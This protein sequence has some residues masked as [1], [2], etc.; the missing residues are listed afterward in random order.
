MATGIGPVTT[1]EATR[2][3]QDRARATHA[4]AIMGLMNLAIR[5]DA[6]IETGQ[7][8]PGNV[9]TI[10]PEALTMYMALLRAQRVDPLVAQNLFQG[11]LEDVESA[12]KANDIGEDIYK[13]K[14]TALLVPYL[15]RDYDA[16]L[17][18]EAH[19][20]DVNGSITPRKLHTAEFI[21][22]ICGDGDVALVGA[23]I[24]T[25]KRIIFLVITIFLV[26]IMYRIWSVSD[27]AAQCNLHDEGHTQGDRAINEPGRG[28][29]DAAGR[30]FIRLTLGEGAAVGVVEEAVSE[31]SHTIVDEVAYRNCN[32][33]QVGAIREIRRWKLVAQGA[34]IFMLT[35]GL[36]ALVLGEKA[37]EAG[38]E[39]GKTALR[40]S[41]TALDLVASVFT[42]HKGAGG[43]PGGRKRLPA[44][45]RRKS[46]AAPRRKTPAPPRR[47]PRLRDGG[48]IGT[49]VCASCGQTA[50]TVCAQ[51]ETTHYCSVDCQR[52]DWNSTHAK[53]CTHSLK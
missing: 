50:T 52:Q 8:V 46:P 3:F 36:S 22:S 23:G 21:A 19:N 5:A 38:T 51:C 49:P 4:N 41:K 11:V 40:T 15:T 28:L 14:F 2:I 13:G 1:E 26:V 17:A 25:K 27:L 34:V 53:V 31:T 20:F 44:P 33:E 43:E 32:P 18:D 10:I 12:S 42:S 47:S 39:A 9:H 16:Y 6:M 45:R 48:N 24:I 29:L 35:F 7:E 37:L 30:I